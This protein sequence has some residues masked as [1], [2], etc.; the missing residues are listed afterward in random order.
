MEEVKM[1]GKTYR[2]TRKPT[3]EN[4][5]GGWEFFI[6][7]QWKTVLSFGIRKD[8]NKATFNF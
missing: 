3:S 1:N 5:F 2:C 7:G 8:L 6:N 4:D